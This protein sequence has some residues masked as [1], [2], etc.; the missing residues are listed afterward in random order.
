M[1]RRINNVS[2][3]AADGVGGQK[4]DSF[5]DRIVK[6]IPGDV[7]A[8]WLAITSAAK[9]APN[10]SSQ[11]LLWVVFAGGV[12]FAAAWTWVKSSETGKPK[13]YTQTAVST[14]AFFV[15]A[16]ATGGAP[17][18]WPGAIY[19]PLHATILMAGFTLLSGLVTKP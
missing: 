3:Q 10:L 16:Y 1:S 14:I 8:G 2:F 11:Q 7:V 9:A 6:L 12:V 4:A 5:T 19:N 15:W 18:L 13:P 17:P